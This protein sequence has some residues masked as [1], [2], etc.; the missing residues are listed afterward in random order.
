MGQGIGFRCKKCGYETNAYCGFGMGY[1]YVYRESMEKARSGGLGEKTRLFFEQHPEG[2]LNCENGPYL[3]TRCGEIEC[4]EKMDLYLPKEGEPAG[5]IYGGPD[6]W[7][8]ELKERY[9]LY[10]RGKHTCGKCGGAMRPN[11]PETLRRKAAEGALRCPSCGGRLE[12]DETEMVL[13][14]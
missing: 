2:A 3:C 4:K 14:D 7:P 12:E 1:S 8:M 9:R 11:S 5:S 6:V 10:A 13:W